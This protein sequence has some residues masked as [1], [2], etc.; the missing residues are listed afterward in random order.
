MFGIFKKSK[1]VRK[2]D[3]LDNTKTKWF[4]GQKVKIKSGTTRSGSQK[5]KDFKD[6]NPTWFREQPLPVPEVEKKQMLISSKDG[7]SKVAILEGPTLVQYYTSEAKSKVGNIYLGKVKNV[8]P[9]MEAA[10]VS[11]GEEKNGVLYVADIEGSYKNS[12][13]ENLLKTDQEILVQV[14]KD[15]IGEKGARLTGQISLPGR[16]LVLIPNSRTKGISRRLSDNER[17]RLNKI[18]RKLKPEN[19]GVIVRTAAELSLIHI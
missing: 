9:G 16:Y 5:N 18:I 4:N 10:F 13:I 3:N 11:F 12:K 1:I 14:V 19:F 17:S 15:A 2:S 6:K 8:L 7:V